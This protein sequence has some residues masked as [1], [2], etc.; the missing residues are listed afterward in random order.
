MA[1]A[2]PTYEERRWFI[3]QIEGAHKEAPR[4]PLPADSVSNSGP[5]ECK[6]LVR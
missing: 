1:R 2:P 6:V 3:N 4:S 5:A